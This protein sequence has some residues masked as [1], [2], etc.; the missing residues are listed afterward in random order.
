MKYLLMQIYYTYKIL[1]EM[2]QHYPN[3][4]FNENKYNPVRSRTY[5][6]NLPVCGIFCIC[7]SVYSQ[8][9]PISR[10]GIYCDKRGQL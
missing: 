2:E 1:H 9:I 3:N 4:G 8:I 7:L 5:P 6:E 10:R